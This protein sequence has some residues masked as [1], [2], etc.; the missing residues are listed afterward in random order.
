VLVPTPDGE[1]PLSELAR[2]EIHQGPAMIRD[3]NGMLAGYVYVDTNARDLG[4]Y[5]GTAQA[6][7]AGSRHAAA[8]AIGWTGPA[9][10]SSRCAR[11]NG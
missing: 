5:V 9:S 7:R 10:T 3:E 11:A 6:G 4:G 8:R 2:I 1:V